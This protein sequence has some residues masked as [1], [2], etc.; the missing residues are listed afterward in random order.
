VLFALRV[1]VGVDGRSSYSMLC[2]D[3]VFVRTCYE[4]VDKEVATVCIP[5]LY[6]PMCPAI[7][8]RPVRS[9]FM[10]DV[11]LYRVLLSKMSMI[12]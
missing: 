4:V 5:L 10:A 2:R 3:E 8:L 7:I 6:I 1:A 12:S 11:K 9:W